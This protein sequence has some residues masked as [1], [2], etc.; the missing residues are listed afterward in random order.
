M[1]LNFNS[2]R[3]AFGFQ[4]GVLL[5]GFLVGRERMAARNGPGYSGADPTRSEI[6]HAH[7]VTFNKDVAPVI[8]RHCSGCH[9]PGEVAPFSLLTYQDVKPR[10]QLVAMVI[11]NRY[12]PPWGPEP[13]YAKFR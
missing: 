9:H 2:R 3:S 8:F 10:A 1:P 4:L 7:L 5:C 12:M 6:P 13:G 11:A